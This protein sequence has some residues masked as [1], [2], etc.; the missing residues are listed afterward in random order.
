MA[1]KDYRTLFLKEFTKNL[2]SNT[3]VN[4]KEIFPYHPIREMQHSLNQ[5]IP[6]ISLQHPVIIQPTPTHL[7][8]MPQQLTQQTTPIRAMTRKI[9]APISPQ[10]RAP[11]F[12]QQHPIQTPSLS[13]GKPVMNIPEN[14][15]LINIAPTPSQLPQNFSLNKLDPLIRDNKV[16]VIECP[17]PGKP[18][19]VKSLGRIFPSQVILN[20]Q[21]IKNTVAIF[22]KFAKIPVIEGI[23]KAAVG[24]LVI[25]SVLSDYVGSRFIINKYTPYSL[26]EGM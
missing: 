8:Q 18:I 3:P 15:A 20:E 25:T 1:R 10:T 5:Q 6:Q 21:E 13:Q 17:G 23:F 11:Q 24:N 4:K 19:L 9:T 22:S 12:L 26:I 14:P 7:V 16:T 2:I